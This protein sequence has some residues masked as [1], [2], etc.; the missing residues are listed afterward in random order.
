MCGVRWRGRMAARWAGG[1]WLAR[2]WRMDG[3]SQDRPRLPCAPRP[4]ARPPSP[5]LLVAIP[6]RRAPPFLR[7]FRSR[8]RLGRRRSRRLRLLLGPPLL[9]LAL[10]LAVPACWLKGRGWGGGVMPRLRALPGVSPASHR[11][12]T[13]PAGQQ[14]DTPTNTLLA[15]EPPRASG[16]PAP[17]R[18][19][20]RRRRRCCARPRRHGA[21]GTR[22]LP[23][24]RPRGEGR[25]GREEGRAARG[26]RCG[27]VQ[28]EEGGA[29]VSVWSSAGE[30]ASVA[31]RGEQVG[32]SMSTSRGSLASLP[33][34]SRTRHRHPPPARPPCL[35][36][37]KVGWE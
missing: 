2:A 32:A 9:L 16:Q 10:A 3:R 5:L 25:E 35:T 23:P 37:K 7:L 26:C 24:R 31:P 29:W 13:K 19:R 12:K 28:G 22:A 30:R 4:P 33:S 36:F 21:A 18:R 27:V 14:R 17:R 11:P 6:R 15:C 8:R 1:G 34:H 20:R